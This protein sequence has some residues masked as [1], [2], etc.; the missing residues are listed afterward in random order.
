[1]QWKLENLPLDYVLQEAR[2]TLH[3]QSDEQCAGK[4]SISIMK[5]CRDCPPQ[6]GLTIA[7]AVTELGSLR[8]VEMKGNN[9]HNGG[10]MAARNCQKQDECNDCIDQQN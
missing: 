5:P 8:A 1:M 3:H 7:G 6:A 4:G 10:Q 9:K 2:R